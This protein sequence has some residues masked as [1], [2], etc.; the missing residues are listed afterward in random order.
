MSLRQ[1]IRQ[2]VQTGINALDDLAERARYTSVRT[3]NYDALTGTISKPTLAYPNVP[4]VFTSYSRQE[5]DGETIRPEDQ[6]AVIAQLA[7]EP[8]PTLNDTIT[9][10][11]G[12]V[13]T[14]VGIRTDPASA[15]WVLQ[16]RRP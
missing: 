13:W 9:R 7:L 1:Q 11:D 14:V 12:S 6:K 2:A 4:M 10:P 3:P 16:V 15:A 5:I 8:V